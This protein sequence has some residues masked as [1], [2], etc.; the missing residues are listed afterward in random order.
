MAKDT[1]KALRELEALLLEEEE[2]P[3][4]QETT[5]DEDPLEDDFIRS[6]LDEEDMDATQVYGRQPLAAHEA[7]KKPVRVHN[8]DKTDLDP[9]IYTDALEEAPQKS[10]AGLVTTAA[11]LCTGILLV[12]IW[13]MIRYGGAFS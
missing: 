12:L 5:W 7:G 13:W 4:Q 6:I 10:L 11:I 9:V 3:E 8:G 1:E 2:A